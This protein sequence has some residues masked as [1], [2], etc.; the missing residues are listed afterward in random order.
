MR[1]MWEGSVVYQQ[2]SERLSWILL[3]FLS[4]VTF[5]RSFQPSSTLTNIQCRKSLPGSGLLSSSSPSPLSPNLESTNSKTEKTVEGK[6][7]EP[8][9]SFWKPKG[10]LSRWEERKH[11]QDLHV[12]QEMYGHV[13]EELLEGKTGPKLFFE[14]GVGRTDRNGT[15]HIVTGMLRLPREKVAV[16]KKRAI[17]LH[18]KDQVPLFVS[19]IQK[20]CGRLEVCA[21]RDDLERYAKQTPR[22]S[23]SSLE[24]NQVLE[25]T[26]IKLYPFGATVDVGANRRGL[27]HIKKVA[28]LY[29]RYINKERGLKDAGIEEGARVRLSVESVENRRLFL[30]F[31]PDVKEEA[32]EKPGNEDT[33]W[34]RST[35]QSDLDAWEEYAKQNELAVSDKG[36]TA[37]FDGVDD[38]DYNYDEDDFDEYDEDSDI[39]KALGL[40]MY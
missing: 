16:T 9:K 10:K 1:K 30:D 33:R 34:S 21:N 22:K 6:E 38:D 39:E 23:V 24:R 4:A 2:R 37:T 5:T 13:V 40:D 27:L 29:G 8:R 36:S 25:G 19:R 26:I 3:T 32:H 18:K 31:T 11:L 14:C 28:S 20:E 35:S 17:R 15:W 12:G 7:L